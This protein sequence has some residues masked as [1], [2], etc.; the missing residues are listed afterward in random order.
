MPADGPTASSPD[1][2]QRLDDLEGVAVEALA[3]RHGGI[4]LHPRHFVKVS[5]QAPAVQT[6]GTTFPESRRPRQDSNLRPRD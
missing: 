6:S 5:T 4:D 2:K 3:A 1:T